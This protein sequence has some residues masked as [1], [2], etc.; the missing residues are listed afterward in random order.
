M[1][2]LELKF[3]T[4]KFNPQ[5]NLPFNFLIPKFLFHGLK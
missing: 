3:P 2:N 5:I 4:Q 1:I